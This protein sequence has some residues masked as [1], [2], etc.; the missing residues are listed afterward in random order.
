MIHPLTEQVQNYISQ[1][2]ELKRSLFLSVREIVFQECPNAIEYFGYGMPAYKTSKPVIYLGIFK[3]HIGLYPTSGP[4][5]KLQDEL[6]EFKTS[7]GAIQIE[8]NKPLPLNLIRLVIQ[9]R[10]AELS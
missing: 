5:A 10:L 7:K 8:I 4:I 3:N 9:T 2:S 6:N 1:T